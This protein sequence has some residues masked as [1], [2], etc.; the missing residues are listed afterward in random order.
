MTVSPTARSAL[1][2]NVAAGSVAGAGSLVFV[3]P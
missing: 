1:G 3:Y 2:V